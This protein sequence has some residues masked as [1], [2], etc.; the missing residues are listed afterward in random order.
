MTSI[1]IEGA[2]LRAGVD[3]LCCPDRAIGMNRCSQSRIAAIWARTR[4][5]SGFVTFG[6]VSRDERSGLGSYQGTA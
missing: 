3:R 6:R 4:L 2:N 1:T 5:A